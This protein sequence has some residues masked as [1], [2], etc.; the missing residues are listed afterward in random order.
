MNKLLYNSKIIAKPILG[1]DLGATFVAINDGNYVAVKIITINE[2]L[3]VCEIIS[4][5][6]QG[7]HIV[8]R[9][10]DL[11]QLFIKIPY[12]D[13][14]IEVL[15]T[16]LDYRICVDLEL[17]GKY[18]Y[19]SIFA[20]VIVFEDDMINKSIKI[21]NTVHNLTYDSFIDIV[22]QFVTLPSKQINPNQLTL[23][24]NV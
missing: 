4:R 14:Y 12:L 11:R 18:C 5:V 6:S 3:A 13:E 7:E 15:L 8:L 2:G 24:S 20:S 22:T 17:I 21:F 19:S 1:E 9:L 16:S 23:F 10:L